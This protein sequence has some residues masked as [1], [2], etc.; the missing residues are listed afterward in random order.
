MPKNVLYY[1]CNWQ[2]EV[3]SANRKEGKVMMNDLQDLMEELNNMFYTQNQ[4]RG[5]PVDV[6]LEN[7]TYKDAEVWFGY[8]CM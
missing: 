5:F 7:N 2:L 3:S 4:N 8:L 1:K 6:T